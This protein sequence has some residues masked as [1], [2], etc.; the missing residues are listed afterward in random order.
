MINKSEI[1]NFTYE[2]HWREPSEKDKD[3]L[4]DLVTCYMN[5]PIID[6]IG[7]DAYWVVDFVNEDSTTWEL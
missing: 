5:T 7:D 2:K 3:M 1:K 4:H 6:H